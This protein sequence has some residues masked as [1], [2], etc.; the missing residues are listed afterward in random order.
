MAYVIVFMLLVGVVLVVSSPLRHPLLS[1]KD[2]VEHARATRE[3][4]AKLKVVKK[5]SRDLDDRTGPLLKER[6]NFKLF[7]PRTWRAPSRNWT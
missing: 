6:N 3:A 7:S 4:E 1:E 2:A 5:W